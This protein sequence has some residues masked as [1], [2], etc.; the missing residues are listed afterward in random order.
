MKAQDSQSMH[1][2]KIIGI[3][4][5]A[6]Q[7]HIDSLVRGSIEETLN[8]VLEAEAEQQ[9]ELTRFYQDPKN[10]VWAI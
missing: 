2:K 4:E 1:P 5:G 6:V 10:H 8:A 3:D 7:S 9:M